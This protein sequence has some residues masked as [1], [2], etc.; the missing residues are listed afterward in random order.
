M[1]LFTK[2]LNTNLN[3]LKNL[4]YKEDIFRHLS[5]K[6]RQ[7]ESPYTETKFNIYIGYVQ[8]FS[9]FSEM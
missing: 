1:I 6:I 9:V 4:I 5:L 2:R 3:I 7:N 8:K